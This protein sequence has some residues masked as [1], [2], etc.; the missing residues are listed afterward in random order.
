M[1]LEKRFKVSF[2]LKRCISYFLDLYNISIRNNQ[3]TAEF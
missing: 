3:K 1:I 2:F